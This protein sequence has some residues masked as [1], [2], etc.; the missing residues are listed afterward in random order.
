[1]I[2]YKLLSE[3][4]VMRI[5]V[6]DPTLFLKIIG[7]IECEIL[8][9]SELLD[10]KQEE[11]IMYILYRDILSPEIIKEAEVVIAGG[12]MAVFAIKVIIDGNNPKTAKGK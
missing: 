12:T 10:V 5:R 1:M 7:G 9:L 6:E 8:Q 4:Q 11:P 3:G 2:Q